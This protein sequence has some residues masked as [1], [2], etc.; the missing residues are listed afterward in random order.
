MTVRST[1]R[2]T[3]TFAA[4]ALAA[5]CL[6]AASP[7]TATATP[8]TLEQ[9]EPVL[10]GH[11]EI[12][13]LPAYLSGAPRETAP[14]SPVAAASLEANMALAAP[15]LG[16]RGPSWNLVALIAGLAIALSAARIAR[17]RRG[18]RI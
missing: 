8:V 17:P 4:A 2:I 12:D 16:D 5:V 15:A 18:A 10:T 11:P 9:I 6:A 3:R 14:A 7:D 13:D 1:H